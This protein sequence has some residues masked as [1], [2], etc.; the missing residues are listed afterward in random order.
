[1]SWIGDTTTRRGLVDPGAGASGTSL[2]EVLVAAAVCMAIGAA[3][4]PRLATHRD[5]ILAAAAARHVASRVYL[6]RAES[7]KRGVHV[8]MVFVNAGA[9]FRYGT[10]A[11]GNRNGVRS[12]EITQ[13]VDRQV[14]SWETLNDHFP[15]AS[16]GILP[17]VTDPDTG[18]PVGGTPL[19]LGGGALL[20][21]GPGGGATSGTLYVRGAG[22]QQYAVRVLGATGRSRVLRFDFTSRRWLP[23]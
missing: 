11:D 12:A 6:T 14:T 22:E 16:F 19:K 4:L 15:G 23:L 21:F 9:G 20:S 13:G 7:L 10:F 1:V 3:A 5:R 2:V 18:S 8:G 17:Q